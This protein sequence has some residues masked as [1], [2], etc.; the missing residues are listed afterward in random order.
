[1]SNII[2]YFTGTGNSLKTAKD[3]AVSLGNCKLVS[4]GKPYKL[5]GTYEHMGFVYPVYCSG[6]PMAVERFIKSLELSQNKNSYIFALCTSGAM[7]GGLKSVS[8]IISEKGGKLSYSANIPC[9]ANYVCLYGMSGDPV[10]KAKSQSDST[11]SAI[12]D[13]KAHVVRKS[14]SD[15]VMPFIHAPFLKSML[16]KEGEYNVSEACSGCGTCSK[17]CPVSN[18]KMQNGKPSFSGHCE[19]CM[20]CIQWC[21]T[22]ALNYKNKTQTRG[23]YHHPD[24]TLKDLIYEE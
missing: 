18:I 8:K 12:A 11:A 14:F 22:Q 5:S 7:G 3:I 23:R 19:Q 21:P 16:K 17:I 4:M 1:M 2:F 6:M 20:A 13:I 24:I 9:F 15:G 10:K